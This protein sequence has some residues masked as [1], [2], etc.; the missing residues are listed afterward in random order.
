MSLAEKIAN[1]LRNYAEITF[2]ICRSSW[3]I[4]SSDSRFSLNSPENFSTCCTY[5]E[6]RCSRNSDLDRDTFEAKPKASKPL[7][8]LLLWGSLA[9]R[10]RG[11]P[12]WGCL[13]GNPNPLRGFWDF[14][15]R[16]VSELPGS[17]KKSQG[18][19][20]LGLP[21]SGGRTRTYDLRVMS[22]T[23]YQLLHPAI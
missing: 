9:A 15:R 22:P 16:L 1:I 5:L 20:S 14:L 8:L 13:L 19:K 17:I 11:G 23:S 6:D 10:S 21:S 18:P 7:V 12:Q 4:C 3:L 2:H